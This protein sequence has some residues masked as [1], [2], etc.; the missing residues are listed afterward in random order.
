MERRTVRSDEP[1]CKAKMVEI[2]CHD[3]FCRTREQLMVS[4]VNRKVSLTI[5]PD[6]FICIASNQVNKLVTNLNQGRQRN[7][8]AVFGI[9]LFLSHIFLLCAL[10]F[11]VRLAC[12]F[13]S[14]AFIVF[15]L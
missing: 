1:L 15:I 12:Y 11:T 5:N 10:C 3:G 2:L 8:S 14:L 7:S 13:M 4:K 6:G 9:L